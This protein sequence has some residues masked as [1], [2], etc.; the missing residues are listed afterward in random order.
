[1]A[2]HTE[3]PA[4]PGSAAKAVT[5]T[6]AYHAPGM[7][8]VRLLLW[9]LFCKTPLKIDIEEW[10]ERGA[11]RHCKITW[12]DYC[13]L[14]AAHPDLWQR[15]ADKRAKAKAVGHFP[16][17]PWQLRAY[18]LREA[19]RR[20]KVRKPRPRFTEW[21]AKKLMRQR[22]YKSAWR[23]NLVLDRLMLRVIGL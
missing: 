3:A 1:M 18:R 5:R 21:A 22:T 19:P 11:A 2:L 15:W 20:A 16:K 12:D 8:R 4:V 9:K 17:Q 10:V 13:R 7:R 14:K 6:E 23:R